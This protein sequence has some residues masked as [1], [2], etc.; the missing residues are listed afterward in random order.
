L[1]TPLL[2]I[3][4]IFSMRELKNGAITLHWELVLLSDTEEDLISGIF[5]YLLREVAYR[6]HDGVF[7]ALDRDAAID[8]CVYVLGIPGENIFT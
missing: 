7:E 1:I 4:E 6:H 5:K 3:T 2:W 8:H